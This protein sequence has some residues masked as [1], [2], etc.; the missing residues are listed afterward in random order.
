MKVMEKLAPSELRQRIRYRRV[1]GRWPNL[2]APETFTE[3]VFWRKLYDCNPLFTSCTDKFLVRRYVEA[4]VGPKVLVPVILDTKH[5]EDLRRLGS[6]TNTVI[7]ANHG[8][9]MM[10]I[11]TDKEP[12][13][14][15]KTRI[16]GQC[17]RWLAMSHA[18]HN[19]ERHY[20]GIDPRIMVERFIGDQR[21]APLDCKIHCFRQEDGTVRK[22]VQLVS[23]RFGT[24]SMCYYIGGLAEEHVV[25]ESGES[26]PRISTAHTPLVIEAMSLSDRLSADFDY[27]RVDWMI[28][29]AELY[30]SELTFTPG[31]GLSQ[32]MGPDLDRALGRI[33]MQ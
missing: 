15:E 33:W 10:E 4:R 18:G 3:K 9:K 17:H 8:W 25:R 29:A 26:P 2:R 22:A 7:K 32:S 27:V 12:W 11:V 16:I 5:P 19:L 1:H 30:F 23:D 24:K 13:E 21:S 6:W 28:T 31:A 20:A 14:E